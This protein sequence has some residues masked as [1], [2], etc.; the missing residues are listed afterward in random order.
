MAE[1]SFIRPHSRVPTPVCMSQSPWSTVMTCTPMSPRTI[2]AACASESPR[3]PEGYAAPLA[4]L[5]GSRPPP[6]R[7]CPPTRTCRGAARPSDAAVLAPQGGEAGAS[8]RSRR[9]PSVPAMLIPSRLGRPWPSAG[10]DQRRGEHAAAQPD[11]LHG[12]GDGVEADQPVEPAH[13]GRRTRRWRPRSPPSPRSASGW[14]RAGRSRGWR[15]AC[16]T[17]TAAA[18]APA[19][20]AGR[21]CRRGRAAAR[22]VRRCAGVPGS[23]PGPRG[24]PRGSNPSAAP[25]SESTTRTDDA[26]A[27]LAAEARTSAAPYTTDSAGEAG[28]R[29]QQGPA[30]ESHPG[31]VVAAVCDGGGSHRVHLVMW[32]GESSR[33]VRSSGICHWTTAWSFVD[34]G[35]PLHAERLAAGA[36]QLLGRR[37]RQQLA[38]RGARRGRRSA[39][40]SPAA[41]TCGDL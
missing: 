11:R 5:R 35:A 38:G 12:A 37:A 26:G 39:A 16:P 32:A 30:G 36:G 33:V 13:P 25:R 41:T 4:G 3:S 23:R 28:R 27:R 7:R 6:G 10:P 40:S 31:E 24:G 15:R 29:A 18:A 34:P 2:R 17:A 9:V 19:R 1:L 14:E 20:G 22:R 21:T 8:T